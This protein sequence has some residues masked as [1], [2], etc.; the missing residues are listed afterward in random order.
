MFFVAVNGYRRRRTHSRPLC[1][2]IKRVLIHR[3]TALPDRVLC[4]PA[5]V[6]QFALSD[7]L[8]LG[9]TEEAEEANGDCAATELLLLLPVVVV[10]G[11]VVV[12]VK[13]A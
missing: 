2:V 13:W 8:I 9:A 12:Y 5:P 11:V 10:A 1:V 4:K 7:A 3:G 6:C